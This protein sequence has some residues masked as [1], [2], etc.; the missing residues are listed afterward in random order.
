MLL[1]ELTASVRCLALVGLAKNTGK[2]LS[3]VEKD[4][5]RDF[6]MSA[7]EAKASERVLAA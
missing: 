1:S 3:Q 2:T 5:E 7:D 4:I 6:F